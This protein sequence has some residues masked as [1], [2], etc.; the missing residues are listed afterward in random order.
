MVI[1]RK[2]ATEIET[3][4]ELRDDILKLTSSVKNASVNFVPCTYNFSWI[5]PI[6]SCD[7]VID[8]EV[9][10]YISQ[11]HPN[12]KNKIDKKLSVAV[13]EINF[14]KFSK[15]QKHS[16]LFSAVSK[17]QPVSVDLNF[18]A[19]S[20]MPYS[21]LSDAIK[22]TKTALSYT[23]KLVDIYKNA[24]TLGNNISYTFNFDVVSHDKTLTC[25]EIN[26]FMNSVIASCEKIGAKLR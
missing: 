16:I 25:D 2:D 13:C 11:L 8:G 23:F 5:H 10:G 17:Y 9:V 26:E 4:K 7:I 21:A 12:V 14:E 1:S 20:E 18:V 19:N 15:T 24:E 3:I 6:N 22:Q